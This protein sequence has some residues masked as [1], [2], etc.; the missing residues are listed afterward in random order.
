VRE[1]V[2]SAGKHTEIMTQRFSCKNVS[3]RLP[4]CCFLAELTGL[5]MK[6]RCL[7]MFCKTVQN[8]GLFSPEEWDC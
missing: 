7:S 6:T 8:M 1:C 3:G 5:L 4:L 2:I